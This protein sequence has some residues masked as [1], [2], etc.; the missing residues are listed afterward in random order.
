MAKTPN[1]DDDSI[2]DALD[3]DPIQDF[4]PAVEPVKAVVEF[5]KEA[6]KNLENDYKYAR[7]NLYN[8][9]ER[10]TDALNGIVD[11][12]QQSQHPR[13]FEVVA[14]LV[15]TLASANKDLLAIQKQVRELQPEEKGPSKV[16]NNLFVG[17]TKDIT[18]L[19]AGTARQI[20]K[21]K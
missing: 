17:S 10:G 15:R 8:V 18:D 21:K 11:L 12:A 2:A 20:N 1:K 14:D 9:I 7:E 5:N 3:L 13:S 4:L 19:L 6:N 16:T